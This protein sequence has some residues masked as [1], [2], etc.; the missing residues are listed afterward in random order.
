MKNDICSEERS[1]TNTQKALVALLFKSSGK[2]GMT[3]IRKSLLFQRD[4]NNEPFLKTQNKANT[5]A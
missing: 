5:E 4:R 2:K 1:H 3:E